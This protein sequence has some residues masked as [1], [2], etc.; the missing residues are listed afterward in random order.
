MKSR[1]LGGAVPDRNWARTL[2]KSLS[3][4][5]FQG[6]LW[7][8]TNAIPL[9]LITLENPISITF[10]YTFPF[11]NPNHKKS[12]VKE[13]EPLNYGSYGSQGIMALWQPRLKL[14][15]A[16][17]RRVSVPV[18]GLTRTIPLPIE[19]GRVLVKGFLKARV[20]S[21]PKG[22]LCAMATNA[23]FLFSQSLFFFHKF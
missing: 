19:I 5:V 18:N 23:I 15:R 14:R 22:M 11:R 9:I 6:E 17:A 10:S 8:S 4:Q 16:K 12:P 3:G 1:G 7:K 13:S 2:S 20:S 21:P